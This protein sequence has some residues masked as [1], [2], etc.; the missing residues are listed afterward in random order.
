MRISR[1]RFRVPSG[2]N[3][4]IGTLPADTGLHVSDLLALDWN[5]VDLNA[6]PP[7]L[8]LSGG[9]P[10]GTKRAPIST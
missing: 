1:K 4:T 2:D 7:E 8:F 5:H 9:P 3:E 10:E 6:D